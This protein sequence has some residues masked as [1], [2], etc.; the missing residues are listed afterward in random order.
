MLI[1]FSNEVS[2]QDVSEHQSVRDIERDVLQ[3]DGE[4]VLGAT[5]GFAGVVA[6]LSQRLGR[7]VPRAPRGQRS[8]LEGL[9]DPGLLGDDEEGALADFSK[10]LLRRAS[11]SCRRSA[12]M[13][14][15]QS[16]CLTQQAQALSPSTYPAVPSLRL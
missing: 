1:G 16:L 14:S 3:L 10:A 11:H 8:P 6:L 4:R 15:M 13:L 12:P 2:G 5:L 9:F 7:L